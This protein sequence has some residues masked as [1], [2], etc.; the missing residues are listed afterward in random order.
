[1]SITEINASDNSAHHAAM[2]GTTA[3]TTMIRIPSGASHVENART[4]RRPWQ[5][6]EHAATQRLHRSLAGIRPAA[7]A[8]RSPARGVGPLVFRRNG[9]HR[10]AAAAHHPR[11]LRLSAGTV[12]LPVPRARPP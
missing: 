9:H 11:L 2:H 10:H 8:A 3:C 12:R 6:H 1:T 7:A 4:L 5:P